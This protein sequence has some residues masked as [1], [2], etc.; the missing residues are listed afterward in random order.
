MTFSLLA[1]CIACQGF[2]ATTPTKFFLTTTFTTPGIPATELSS[3]L[4]T[5]APT[6]GGRTTRPCSMPGTRTLCTN[7]NCPV[8]IAGMSRRGTGCAEHGPFAGRL[9]LGVG[10]E[11]QVKLLP[12]D[13]LAVARPFWLAS[14]FTLMTP[15][16]AAS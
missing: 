6:A 12:A 15:S 7:S 13:Q 1:A 8:T 10:I 9:A 3:T 14:L 16:L 5:V 4:T 11:L 2:S